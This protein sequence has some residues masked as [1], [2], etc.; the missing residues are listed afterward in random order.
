MLIWVTVPQL[1]ALVCCILCP[2]LV[3]N[4]QLLLLLIVVLLTYLQLIL[5]IVWTLLP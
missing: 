5:I 4:H 3:H 1:L 2:R